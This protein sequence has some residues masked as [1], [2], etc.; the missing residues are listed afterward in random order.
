MAE[1]TPGPWRADI[2]EEHGEEVCH[3]VY[4]R[5]ME[6]IVETDCG[7]DPPRPPDARLIAAAPVLLTAVPLPVSR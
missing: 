2:R 6:R 5:K 4:A 3:G 1:H 7:F